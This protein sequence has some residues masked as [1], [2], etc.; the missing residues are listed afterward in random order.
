MAS[1]SFSHVSQGRL[2]NRG[3]DR[4]KKGHNFIQGNNRDNEVQINE[5]VIDGCKVSDRRQMV[6]AVVAFWE[7]IGGT[8]EP[9]SE[10]SHR[11]RVVTKETGRRRTLLDPSVSAA[12]P[13]Y[14]AAAAPSYA[15]A[16]DTATKT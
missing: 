14:A 3:S 6:K 4:I 9:L 7:D 12:A 10:P 2:K 15:A 8:N 1:Q 16:A 11:G 13:S 5:L